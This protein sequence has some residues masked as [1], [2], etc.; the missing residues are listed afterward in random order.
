MGSAYCIELWGRSQPATQQMEFAV[1][2]VV[3]QGLEVDGDKQVVDF[4]S[5][6]VRPWCSTNFCLLD[7]WEHAMEAAIPAN[8]CGLC[9]NFT[10]NACVQ[11]MHGIMRSSKSLDRLEAVT[12][13]I[14]K[15]EAAARG[16]MAGISNT[17]AENTAEVANL[18]EELKYA[19]NERAQVL[20]ELGAGEDHGQDIDTGV[21]VHD[22]VSTP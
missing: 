4:A 7:E 11:M 2:F 12:R 20:Q 16:S 9:G 22:I 6:D 17:M 5:C 10:A 15:L 1:R 21:A 19:Y 14:A 18:R 3:T 13:R 8:W